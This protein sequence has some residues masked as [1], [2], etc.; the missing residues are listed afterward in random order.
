MYTAKA[1]LGCST[2]IWAHSDTLFCSLAFNNLLPAWRDVLFSLIYVIKPC[3]QYAYLYSDSYRRSW[4]V[5]LFT[6]RD[7]CTCSD[8]CP[9]H[10]PRLVRTCGRL[11]LRLQMTG[12]QWLIHKRTTLPVMRQPDQSRFG[13]IGLM[14]PSH[15]MRRGIVVHVSQLWVTCAKRAFL[16]QTRNSTSLI[17]SS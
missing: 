5:S 12:F 7:S 14:A 9:Q 10:Y 4:P 3:V 16:L 13:G 2:S 1:V 11:R 17:S 6:Y 15:V 8:E